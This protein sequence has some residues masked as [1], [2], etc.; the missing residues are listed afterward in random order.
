MIK[1]IKS[2]IDDNFKIFNG[3]KIILWGTKIDG[4]LILNLIEYY[5]YNVYAFCDNNKQIQNSKIDGIQV[6]SPEKL[7]E[8][9]KDELLV[10]VCSKLSEEEIAK[11]L[12][13]MGIN[14]YIPLGE[15]LIKLYYRK[16]CKMKNDNINLDY[17]Q[18]HY[19][20]LNFNNY[21]FSNYGLKDLLFIC[22]PPKTAD[23][24]LMKTFDKNN[25]SYSQMWHN[26]INFDKISIENLQQKVKI[27]T[28]VR[29]PISYDLSVL[30]QLL[31][32][33]H[34]MSNLLYSIYEDK[35]PETGIDMQILFDEWSKK[36]N[37]YC[38]LSKMSFFYSVFR[39]RILDIFKYP[40]DQE[41]GYTI[42]KEGNMEVFVYQ[43][44]K[45]NNIVPELAE[46][47]GGNFT[48]L[49]ILNKADKKWYSESY[50]QAKKEIKISKEYFEQC[51]NEYFIE[52][53]YSY[54]DID[55]F[56]SKWRKN[57]QCE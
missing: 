47:V 34:G 43:L 18:E 50:N 38:E 6:L 13:A 7:Q 42:I 29:E 8:E 16:I 49:E 53:F 20:S 17:F 26:P 51:Y 54:K 4:I 57:V 55:K 44:E 19:T 11:Q 52:Y 45:L 14:F 30:Y 35:I 36:D 31:D 24:S 22:M 27:I 15:A 12:K 10:I 23:N 5:G 33:L 39:E 28:S 9:N 3:K 48:E 41:K 46:F 1:K 40:F 56:K 25:I 2:C 37:K 21:I 32:N